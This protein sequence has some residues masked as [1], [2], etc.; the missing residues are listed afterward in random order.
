LI[1]IIIRSY[2]IFPVLW[3]ILSFGTRNSSLLIRR[4]SFQ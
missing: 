2:R 3:N 4:W 1:G